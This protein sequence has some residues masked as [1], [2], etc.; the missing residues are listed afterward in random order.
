[1]T[2]RPT[3]DNG[4]LR[5]NAGKPRYDLLEPHAIAELVRV[6]TAGA[7]KYKA[8]NWLRGMD[9]SKC[10][11][12]LQRHLAAW[13]MGEDRDPE[14]GCLHMAH[15]AWNALALVSYK[16]LGLGVDDRFHQPKDPEG[17]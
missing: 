1:M 3:A 15:V 16:L 12:S 17:L 4:G 10:D 13:R 14:T 5:D 11:A 8:H 7:A 2:E 6:F 9:W